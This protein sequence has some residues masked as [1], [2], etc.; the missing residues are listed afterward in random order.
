M[1]RLAAELLVAQVEAPA[2]PPPE[3]HF[4]DAPLVARASTRAPAPPGSR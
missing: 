4:L 2:P 1:G 3:R